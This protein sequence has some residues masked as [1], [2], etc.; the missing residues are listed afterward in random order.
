REDGDPHAGPGSLAPR[1]C[2]VHRRGFDDARRRRS[3]ARRWPGSASRLLLTRSPRRSVMEGSMPF[4][5]EELMKLMGV[6]GGLLLGALFI[7]FLITAVVLEERRKTRQNVEYEQSRREI[8]A[9]VA[10]GSISPADASKL[11]ASGRSLKS[12]ILDDA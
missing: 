1:D 8:A 12:R 6:A 4:D 3:A 7:G 5:A 10:E 11:L 2:R 9:Y